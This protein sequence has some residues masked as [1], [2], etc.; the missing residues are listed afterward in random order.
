MTTTSNSTETGR[1]PGRLGDPDRCLRTD[2]RTDPRTVEALAPFGLDVN[3]APAPIG[4]DAPRE[5]QLEYA[6]GAEAAFEG[7]FAALMDGLDPV[8]G[9]ERRTETISG[10]AG[11]E[12]K[13]Y[14]HRPAGAVG[15]LP[16]IFHIHGGGM[17]ILQAAG[18]VYVRFRD[19]LAATGTVVVG[20][21]YRNGAG[22]LGPHPFPAGLHDCAVALDWVHARRAELGISTL[23]VA[24]ESGGGNLTLATAIRAKREGRLDAIDGVY[25]LVP[26]ISGMYGRSREEREAELPSLVE[27]DGYFISCDLCAVFVE[28][29][30]PGTAHLTD[31]LAWPYHAAREDL[32]GL[33]PHVIS[34]NEV[35]PLRDEGL[36]YYRKLVEAGV[37]AR[38]RV[39]PGACHAA[40]MMFRKAAPD[41]YEATVQDIHDFVTSLHR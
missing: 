10:P 23:T 33:P 2:P 21:E 16:G 17:V 26:Y 8:P 1:R 6:M 41:M 19:E 24:G 35:D 22:V 18:P 31:P 12:I 20:V 25:A 3:A 36:A 9:I 38:S 37:E 28:V 27:C 32:I 14:V 34:V 40:D 29:Y 15:P 7:V 30:D 13:L 5:Q 11:N 39:V 4:P